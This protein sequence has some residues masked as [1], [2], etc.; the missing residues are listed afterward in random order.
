MRSDDLPSSSLSSSNNG[1][2]TTDDDDAPPA[3]DAYVA[4]YYGRS[5]DPN[6]KGQTRKW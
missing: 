4:E 3:A 6:G 1:D 2:T 5:E